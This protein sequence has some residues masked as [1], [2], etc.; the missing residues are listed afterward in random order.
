MAGERD[1]YVL[2]PDRSGE[3]VLV[4]E[5]KLPCVRGGRGAAGAVEALREKWVLDAPYLRPAALVGYGEGQQPVA[6]LHEFDAPRAA[7]E[8]PASLAWIAVEAA[9][10][11]AL[12]PPELTPFVESWLAIA[13]GG[14][15]PEKRAPWARPGWWDEACRWLD[16]TIAG[17]G[18]ARTGPV[19]VVQQWPLSSVL[20]CDTSDGRV[21]FKAAFAIFRHEHALTERLAAEHPGLV[22]EVLAVDA[23]RGWMLM[24]ELRGAPVGDA[25]IDRRT[26]A[27]GAIARLHEGWADRTRE[28]LAL[29]A[30]NRALAALAPDIGSTFDAVGIDAAESTVHDLERRCEELTRGQLPETLVH[31]DFHPWNVMADGKELRIF[32]WSDASVAHPLF[33]LATLFQPTDDETARSAVLEAYLA[34]WSHL[35]SAAELRAEYELARP[36]AHVHQA[37]SYLRINEALAPDERW[38]FADAPRQWLAGAV[39]AVEGRQSE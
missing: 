21:Y 18:V 16:E 27:A 11:A 30:Q 20:R 38:W 14:P 2:V 19:E 1:I 22:P 35:A 8:P 39:E 29:G 24:R 12:A 34:A 26:E 15:V 23:P 25:V 28:L 37:I 36:L 17:A 7:W 32:D 4:D 10:P 13:R 3:R 6:A 31:G 9:D 5:A 33:D